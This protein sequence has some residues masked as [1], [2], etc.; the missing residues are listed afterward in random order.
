MEITLGELELVTEIPGPQLIQVAAGRNRVPSFG[1]GNLGVVE[2]GLVTR[3]DQSVDVDAEIS[4]YVF[5]ER[6]NVL[7]YGGRRGG[8]R[9]ALRSDGGLDVDLV[10]ERFQLSDRSSC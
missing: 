10:F 6:G 5:F 7:P 4:G 1:G 2:V 8:G 9:R 3:V